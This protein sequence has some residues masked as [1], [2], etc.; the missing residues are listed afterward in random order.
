M[1]RFTKCLVLLGLACIGLAACQDDPGEGVVEDRAATGSAESIDADTPANAAENGGSIRVLVSY[2]GDAALLPAEARVYVFARVPGTTMPIGVEALNPGDLPMEINFGNPQS[3]ISSAEV[4]ARLSLTGSVQLE[5][6]DSQVVSPPMSFSVGA[7]PTLLNIPVGGSDIAP[8]D[9]DAFV[10]VDVSL[11]PE[12]SAP[13]ETTVFVVAREPS[14]LPV[15]VQKLTVA[16]LPTTVRLSDA[17]SMFQT[18]RLSQH[19]TVCVVARV[20]A[21]GQA[22]AQAGDWQGLAD[23]VS[24]KVHEPVAILIDTQIE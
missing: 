6:G 18:N 2:K 7:E 14:G 21:S 16:D 5:P 22:I 20:A 1:V 23:E 8:K 17:Q 10:Y 9:D 4:V 24:T 19:Q 13:A 15:A 11:A 3:G 12:I